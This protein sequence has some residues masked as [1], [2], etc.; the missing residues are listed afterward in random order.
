VRKAASYPN[1]VYVSTPVPGG[2][3]DNLLQFTEND[4]I[5]LNP[6][7]GKITKLIQNKDLLFFFQSLGYG[8]ISAFDRSLTKDNSGS[9]LSLGLGAALGGF[10]YIS[11]MYGAGDGRLVKVLNDDL[12]FVD[13]SLKKLYIF[14]NGSSVDLLSTCNCKNFTIDY[15]IASFGGDRDFIWMRNSNGDV[16]SYNNILKV[17]ESYVS[18]GIDS[19]ANH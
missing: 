17:A 1:R 4:Y 3:S 11:Q 18:V 7:F 2:L 19:G 12:A 5:D 13:T 16:L 9:N 14:S 15:T 8:V 6:N 10:N